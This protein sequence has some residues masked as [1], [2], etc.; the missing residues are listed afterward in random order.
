MSSSDY[1][2]TLGVSRSA[3]ADEIKKAYRKL[4]KKF[5]PDANPDDSGAQQKFAEITEAYEVL[6]DED[7]RRKYDQF[8]Q[9]WNKFGGAGGGNPFEGF[10][11]RGGSGGVQFDLDDILGGMFGGGG[12]GFGGGGRRQP[13]AQKGQNVDVEIH[14]PFQVGVE[15]GE[16]ELTLQTSGKTE[17]LTVRVPAGIDDGGK[18][19]LAGQGYPGTG[20][21]AAGDVIVT[22][23]V[24]P[25]PWFRREGNNLLV[26]VP[27]TPTEAAIGGRIDVP[28]LTEGT[29]VLTIPPGTSSGAK[30]RIRGKGVPDRKTKERGDQLVVIKI[31]SPKNLTDEVKA[32]FEQIAELAPQNPRSGLWG[33][34]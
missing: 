27:V 11:G 8:G 26:E 22:V 4:A 1:Y 9:N 3:T 30:L 34:N 31:A 12:G 13:R 21:G 10:N 19:R 18:I 25:H 2:Q 32:L 20:G 7:K 14:V 33:A 6:S 24:S 5:H 17:R 15:G 23:R 28:T 16:H 29:I